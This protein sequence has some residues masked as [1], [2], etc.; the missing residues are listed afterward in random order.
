MN[1]RY[2]VAIILLFFAWKG[3]TLDV[4]WPPASANS[5]TLTRPEPEQIAWAEPLQKILPKMLPADRQYLSA[6]YEALSYVLKQDGRRSTPIIDTTDKFVA[7]HAGSLQL[8]IE[9]A[10]VG[11][12]T[13]L[14]AAIDQVFFAANGVDSAAVDKA[15]RQKLADACTVLAWV[16][17]IHHE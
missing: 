4:E 9:K 13:G 5:A 8:A 16:F 10:N 15:S 3:A 7:M 12:Y 17:E 2:V 11:K 1:L 14:D 6:F